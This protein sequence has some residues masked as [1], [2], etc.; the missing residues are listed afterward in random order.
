VVLI[1]LD[2]L[3]LRAVFHANQQL[4]SEL[5]PAHGS[6]LGKSIPPNTEFG[7]GA[8]SGLLPKRLHFQMRIGCGNKSP[9]SGSPDFNV[10][11][12]FAENEN[13]NCSALM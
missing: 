2:H 6:D 12:H 9:A 1:D 3:D 13:L 11:V 8:N 10:N 7:A 4:Q 5:I